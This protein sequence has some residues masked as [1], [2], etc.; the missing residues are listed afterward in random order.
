[1]SFTAINRTH[2]HG[3]AA[4]L[5][6]I[7]FLAT[8]PSV[9]HA[10]HG[11]QL[12][13]PRPGEQPLTETSLLNVHFVDRLTGF[14]VGYHGTVLRTTDGEHWEKLDIPIMPDPAPQLWAVT[15]DE[16]GNVYVG[17]GGVPDGSGGV[18]WRSTDL[19]ENWEDISMAPEFDIVELLFT[20]PSTV[21]AIGDSGNVGWVHQD[22]Q[23]VIRKSTDAGVTWRT[24]ANEVSRTAPGLGVCM[25]DIQFPSRDTGWAVGE[26]AMLLRSVDGGESWEYFD[27][28]SHI[29]LY[30]LHFFSGAEGF[31]YGEGRGMPNTVSGGMTW[32]T[33][34]HNWGYIF[35]SYFVRPDLGFACNRGIER[36]TD[37]GRTW[38]WDVLETLDPAHPNATPQFRA[39]TFSDPLHGWAV[40][41]GG[42]IYRTTSGGV[43]SA[44][45]PPSPREI[46]MS[47][48]P[49]P[50]DP[51]MHSGVVTVTLPASQHIRLVLHDLLGRPVREL[52]QG[53]LTAGRHSLRLQTHANL[54]P[55]V[56]FLVLRTAERRISEKML[57]QE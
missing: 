25:R 27:T 40:G 10:Q 52:Y 1:M 3:A 29:D 12:M 46:A 28:W 32:D 57:V 38:T 44:A 2:A 36:T 20:D 30:G 33:L 37:R 24:V 19:G 23:A 18:L 42:V 22:R 34:W 11:W 53:M 54:S 50:L 14:I 5:L 39:M 15:S 45:S 49:Q 7:L 56:Y 6:S 51:R 8:V 13:H 21:Y 16:T 41:D 26:H 35:D 17:G 43:V 4:A 31:V 9:L 55:G 48:C 47:V